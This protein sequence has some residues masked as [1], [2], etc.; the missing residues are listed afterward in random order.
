VVGL[1]LEVLLGGKPGGLR[2][3]DER[4]PLGRRRQRR[5]RVRGRGDRVLAVD[6]AWSREG[7]DV[8]PLGTNR[9]VRGPLGVHQSVA[10]RVLRPSCAELRALFEQ[11][12]LSGRNDLRA[13]AR[14]RSGQRGSRGRGRWRTSR[15]SCRLSGVR[16][17]CFMRP[18]VGRSCRFART[19][20]RCAERADRGAN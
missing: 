6:R 12:R 10:V 17:I 18:A 9:H 11:L 2:L 8:L 4:P 13:A 14:R 5:W 16:I 15:R 7:G 1:R 20:G 19:V 3:T